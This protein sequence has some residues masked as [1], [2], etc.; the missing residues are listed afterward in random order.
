MDQLVRWLLLG[1]VTPPAVVGAIWVVDRAAGT[2]WALPIGLLC[3]VV[4]FGW[5]S[6]CRARRRATYVI[7]HAEQQNRPA[8]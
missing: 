2:F 7:R 1:L 8:A 3:V 4:V 5:D 6:A